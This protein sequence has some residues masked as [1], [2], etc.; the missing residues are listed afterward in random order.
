MPQIKPRSKTQDMHLA[1]WS[2]QKGG[3]GLHNHP[4]GL[5]TGPRHQGISWTTFSTSH[6]LADAHCSPVPQP[7]VFTAS[8]PAAKALTFSQDLVSS[9]SSIIA[10]HHEVTNRVPAAPSLPGCKATRSRHLLGHL[11]TLVVTDIKRQRISFQQGW[12]KRLKQVQDHAPHAGGDCPHQTFAASRRR[13]PKVET[14]HGKARW[15]V[16]EEGCANQV[17]TLCLNVIATAT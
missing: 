16:F 17:Q 11:R 13:F 5:C 8:P 7:D 2:P 4:F 14:C 15:E 3:N 1:Q 10:D 9:R 6:A 12:E